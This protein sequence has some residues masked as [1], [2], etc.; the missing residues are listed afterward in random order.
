MNKNNK[1]L[2][3]TIAA[4]MTVVFALVSCSKTENAETADNE[5]VSEAS[6]P[7]PSRPVALSGEWIEEGVDPSA[8][9]AS[10]FSATISDGAI[11]IRRESADMS[12]LYW[13]GT[14]AEKL[15]PGETFVSIADHAQTDAALL[16]SSAD[17]KDFVFD[18]TSLSFDF[19]M[20]GVTR[21][22]HIAPKS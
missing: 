11:T 13:A 21:T 8:Q 9:D 17:D 15:I 3:I 1:R 16:A 14:M 5:I 20:M 10:W 6:N 7:A 18:G 19:S 22:I 2:I 12:A 4:L